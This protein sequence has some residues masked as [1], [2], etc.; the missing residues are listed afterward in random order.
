MI[1]LVGLHLIGNEITAIMQQQLFLNFLF[2]DQIQF[3][4]K[5][6]LPNKKK[7]LCFSKLY[8][9][10]YRHDVWNFKFFHI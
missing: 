5:C 1:V 4:F 7:K 8:N 10:F 9:A 2:C 6:V 3:K